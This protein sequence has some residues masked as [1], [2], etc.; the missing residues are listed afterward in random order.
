MAW[1]IQMSGSRE[2]QPITSGS[3]PDTH[4]WA[5]VLP[6][7]PNNTQTRAKPGFL[8]FA[9]TWPN[10]SPNLIIHLSSTPLVRCPVVPSCEFSSQQSEIYSTCTTTSG[11][12]L[13]FGL[14][15][16]G[17]D[18]PPHKPQKSS[19][20]LPGWIYTFYG[21]RKHNTDWNMKPSLWDT[22]TII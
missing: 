18:M 10:Q 11:W 2:N 20:C 9:P 4:S 1:N 21:V 22:M 17:S 12:T 7:L 14:G 16:E 6:W 13:V 19:R 5:L 15:L 3:W 8:E